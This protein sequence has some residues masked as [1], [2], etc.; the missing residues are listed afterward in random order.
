MGRTQPLPMSA[1]KLQKLRKLGLQTL[2]PIW[3][4]S[5]LPL[6]APFATRPLLCDRH[7]VDQSRASDPGG[8]EQAGISV[9][10]FKFLE[11]VGVA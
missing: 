11:A 4:S 1:A 3:R 9:V 5:S 2:T 8:N 10:G 6:P 7:V